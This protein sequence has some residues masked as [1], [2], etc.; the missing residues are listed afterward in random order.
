MG[1]VYKCLEMPYDEIFFGIY[2]LLKVFGIHPILMCLML[3][4]SDSIDFKRTVSSFPGG[5]PGQI[6]IFID[7]VNRARLQI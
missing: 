4:R 5:P 6:L 3:F 7:S 1:N 2:T